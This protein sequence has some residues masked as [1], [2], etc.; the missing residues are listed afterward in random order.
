MNRL[1]KKNVQLSIVLLFLAVVA[2]W[3]PLSANSQDAKPAPPSPV[4][5]WRPNQSPG[6]SKFLGPDACAECHR[7]KVV[8]QKN[9]HMGKALLT[10]AESEI[11]RANPKLT[12]RQ[13]PY[14]YQ[15]LREGNG[16][17][18]TVMDGTNTISIPLVYCFGSGEAG[19]TYVLQYRDKYYESRVSFYD[20]LRGLDITMGHTPNLPKNLIEAM[21]REMGMEETRNCFGCH[22]TN[23]V[24]GKTL[25]L[26]HLMRGVTCEA[27]HG[28]GE[29]HVTAMKAGE[30]KQKQVFNPKTLSTEELSNFCGSC[31]RSWEQVALM[32]LRGVNN[33]RFQPYRLTNSKCYDSDDK[34]ISCT[35]CH[36]P[37]QE[38][39]REA[40]YYDAKCTAC[41]NATAKAAAVK[42][43]A[44][45]K[46]VAQ[47]CKVGK[48]KCASCHMP[49][50]E[51][52]GSHFKFSDHQIRIVRPGDEY[53]N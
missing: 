43:N 23:G 41:H 20:S 1:R 19:Q 31:H 8:S 51:I 33:V 49:K 50:L 42:L 12:F 53:P 47:V 13:G 4:I 26:D 11:L 30:F 29:T 27:C 34:R 3:L 39:K 36:D 2:I 25:Q 24:N 14:A 44:S 15:I 16:S 45:S 52:P 40:A 18:Y 6:N 37:H 46:R 5:D 35:A 38:R 28:P 9:T 32:G 7:A 48:A 17:V 10:A 22:T 21:G